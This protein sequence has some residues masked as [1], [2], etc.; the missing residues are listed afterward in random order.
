MLQRQGQ[1]SGL[2]SESDGQL[3][4]LAGGDAVAAASE[5]DA[6]QQDPQEGQADEEDESGELAGARRVAPVERVVDVLAR[7]R[8]VD[9]AEDEVDDGVRHWHQHMRKIHGVADE[10]F[11]KPS[12][13]AC[14]GAGRRG[15]AG[16]SVDNLSF[17]TQYLIDYVRVYE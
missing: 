11:H 5:E 14:R 2:V 15:G 1:G 16:G 9:H 17:P 4:A 10:A 6:V 13:T 8:P 12:S 3:A 7:R